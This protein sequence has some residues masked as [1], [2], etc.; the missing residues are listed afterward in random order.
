M[1]ESTPV[2][3]PKRTP[4]PEKWRARA[5]RR[6]EQELPEP[7]EGEHIVPDHDAGLDGFK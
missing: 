7:N 4:P 2:P 3:P 5:R 1:D 6:Y